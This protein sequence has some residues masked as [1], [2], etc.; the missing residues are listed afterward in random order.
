MADETDITDVDTT[1]A[2]NSG[3]PVDENT[4]IP[5]GGVDP[6]AAAEGDGDPGED[7]DSTD[8]TYDPKDNL[9]TATWGDFK[10]D[11]ANAVLLELQNSGITVDKAKALLFDALKS[12]DVTKIDHD[13][14]VE[15]VGKSRAHLIEAGMRDFIGRTNAEVKAAE[16]SAKAVLAE[17]H[18]AAGGEAAW[19]KVADWARKGGVDKAKLESYVKLI[20]AGGEQAAFAIDRIINAYNS[21]DT[22][23]SVTRKR[24]MTK[25]QAEAPKKTLTRQ[26]YTTEVLKH[27]ANRTLTPKIKQELLAARI[28]DRSGK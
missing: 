9:D 20:D 10:D 18:A 4:P 23:T 5:P 25:A 6:N 1:D 11:T 27:H 13:A 2:E 17:M 16:E 3:T 8:D 7:G 14:L 12:G 19:K 26:E 28:A 15:A 21:V 22:H 24:T